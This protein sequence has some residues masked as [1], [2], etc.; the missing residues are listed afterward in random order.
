MITIVHVFTCVCMIQYI[1]MGELLS[2]PLSSTSKSF[3]PL[4]TDAGV[5]ILSVDSTGSIHGR[6]TSQNNFIYSVGP[7]RLPVRTP[8]LFQF[9]FTFF[10]FF[11]LKNSKFRV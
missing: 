9:Q 11:A 4:A 1:C 8:P 6:G 7:R 5:C 10:F 2:F 3:N